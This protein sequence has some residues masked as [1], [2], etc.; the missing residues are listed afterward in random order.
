MRAL[1]DGRA[2]LMA[3]LEKPAA[4]EIAEESSFFAVEN[5]DSDFT[6]SFRDGRQHDIHDS[7]AADDQ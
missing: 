3:K 6:G 4:I 5:F 1:I 7:N 2:S